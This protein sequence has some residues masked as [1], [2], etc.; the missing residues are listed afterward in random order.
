MR[1]R[2]RIKNEEIMSQDN[3]ENKDTMRDEYDFSK[4]SR[5]RHHEQYNKGTN[6]VLLEEDVAEV[7]KDSISVNEA[8]RALMRVA[9]DYSDQIRNR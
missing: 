5:G 8:L 7:F 4:G 2:H 6:V 1:G 3:Q 9:E